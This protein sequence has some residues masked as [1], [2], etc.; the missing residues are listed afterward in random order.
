MSPMKPQI[1]AAIS[2]ALQEYLMAEE[3]FMATAMAAPMPA[4]VGP[5]PN[6]WGL[7]GRQAAMQFRLLMQR[8]SLR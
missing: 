2:A 8:R 3:A 7:A 6:L 1:M 4:A 5:P